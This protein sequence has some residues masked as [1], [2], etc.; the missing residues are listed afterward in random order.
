MSKKLDPALLLA[1]LLPIFAVAPFVQNAGIPNVADGVIH[2]LRQVDFDRAFRSGALV[3]RWGAD[4]YLGFGYPLYNFAPPLLA[5]LVEAFH[6]A[7]MAMDDA[8]KLV[9]VLTLELYSVG[10][11]LFM[12]PKVGELGALAAAALNVYA[13]LRMREALVTGGN[14]PQFLAMAL[15]PLILWAF[16][17]VIGTSQATVIASGAKQSPHGEEIASAH[18]ARLAMTQ[19]RF[20][21]VAALSVA[22][23]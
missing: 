20:V 8:L 23:L 12:R 5:Y 2:L 15:F 17:G 18:T 14:Y 10:M 13:P 6:L 16:D 9:V 3:P 4:L 22:A 19:R 11:F 21:A 7:G 1:F